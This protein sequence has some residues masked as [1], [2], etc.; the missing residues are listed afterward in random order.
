MYLDIRFILLLVIQCD[1][2]DEFMFV[3]AV[4]V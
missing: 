1:L 2:I 3:L 4:I